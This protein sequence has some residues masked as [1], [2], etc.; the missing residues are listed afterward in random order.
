[1]ITIKAQEPPPISLSR[2][3]STV[4]KD[5]TLKRRKSSVPMDSFLAA[6]NKT[7]QPTFGTPSLVGGFGSIS[8]TVET[9]DWSPQFGSLSSEPDPLLPKSS[10]SEPT[11]LESLLAGTSLLGEPTSA[12][13]RVAEDTNMKDTPD[14]LKWIRRQDVLVMGGVTV[15]IIVLLLSA[16]LPTWQVQQSGLWDPSWDWT[17]FETSETTGPLSMP[18]SE[19][20]DS[21]EAY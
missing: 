12:K 20:W 2:H 15:A 16:I 3:N 13:G 4:I 10:N 17:H 5:T 11:G 18:T 14:L 7:S 19:E 1:M 8:S 21:A 9:M 6:K